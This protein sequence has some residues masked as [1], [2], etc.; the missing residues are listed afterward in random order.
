MFPRYIDCV[1]P[2]SA[3][4]DEQVMEEQ[5]IQVFF[6]MNTIVPNTRP[7][8]WNSLRDTMNYYTI[9]GYSVDMLRKVG[10]RVA[11]MA[12]KDSEKKQDEAAIYDRILAEALHTPRN[13]DAVQGPLREYARQVETINGCLFARYRAENPYHPPNSML[14]KF[15]AVMLD[16][17]LDIM[18]KYAEQPPTSDVETKFR[19]RCDL[20]PRE[21]DFTKTWLVSTVRENP[22]TGRVALVLDSG[23]LDGVTEEVCVKL[24]FLGAKVALTYVDEGENLA[25]AN[26]LVGKMRGAG[27]Q[28]VA[29]EGKPYRS[30]VYTDKEGEQEKYVKDLVFQTLRTFHSKQLHIIGT[31]LLT[32]SQ[33]WQSSSH[34]T[35]PST[36]PEIRVL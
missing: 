26:E 27:G 14:A 2:S 9:R 20:S 34:P 35:I 3:N 16:G 33:Y 11:A 5:G 30:E 25:K 32:S 4:L 19:N 10:S 15:G 24:T 1:M 17:R 7:I 8:D 29:L 6:L 18:L 12:C 36:N 23:R 21:Y 28:A 31:Y 13:W 22:L